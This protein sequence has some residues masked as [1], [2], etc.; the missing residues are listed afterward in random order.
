MITEPY[1]IILLAVILA[2]RKKS[3]SGR[4]QSV[5]VSRI[6]ERTLGRIL[7]FW[8]DT[9][10]RNTSVELRSMESPNWSGEHISCC[11]FCTCSVRRMSGDAETDTPKSGS[12]LTRSKHIP[13][14]VNIMIRQR[15][16][17]RLIL[18]VSFICSTSFP[19]YF[20]KNE[21]ILQLINSNFVFFL[22]FWQ[23]TTKENG[24]MVRYFLGKCCLY[25]NSDNMKKRKRILRERAMHLCINFLYHCNILEFLH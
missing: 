2:S 15:L 25:H 7:F 16:I 24:F 3:V 1:V 19:I 13:E 20:S 21:M 10:R 5:A 12:V 4:P 18:Y 8:P 17:H 11:V 9:I 14:T 22:I 23:K 6:R